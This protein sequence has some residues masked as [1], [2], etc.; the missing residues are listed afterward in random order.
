MIL[1][2][3][4][5]VVRDAEIFVERRVPRVS[6]D[7]RVEID[8]FFYSIPHRLVREQIDLRATKRRYGGRRH[9]T[10]DHL[11]SAHRRYAE[12]TP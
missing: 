8:G 4:T 6:L 7:H 2:H 10:A 11:P 3:E 5:G 1:D 9:G 12:W